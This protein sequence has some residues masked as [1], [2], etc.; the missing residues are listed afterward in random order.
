MRIA[1]ISYQ[2]L[3]SDLDSIASKFRTKCHVILSKKILKSLQDFFDDWQDPTILI[4]IHEESYQS[5]NLGLGPIMTL[6]PDTIWIFQFY[7]SRFMQFDGMKNCM[8][9]NSIN[10]A[11]SQKNYIKKLVRINK[12]RNRR[13]EE[14]CLDAESIDSYLLQTT[15]I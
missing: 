4:R 14:H 9:H 3:H 13:N 7:S 1:H 12:P 6:H 8:N 5:H 2:Y 15:K 11:Q 10:N